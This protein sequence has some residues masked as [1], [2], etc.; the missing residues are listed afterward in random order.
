MSD[1]VPPNIEDGWRSEL[2]GLE[3]R[4]ARADDTQRAT[5][6]ARIVA[7]RAQLGEVVESVER[8]PA[9]ARRKANGAEI[10]PG[11]EGAEQA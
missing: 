1:R 8:H 5:L 9:R 6:E 3:A 4:L 10:R 7:V 2:R 11:G